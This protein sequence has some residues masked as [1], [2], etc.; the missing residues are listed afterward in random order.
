[1]CRDRWVDYQQQISGKLCPPIRKFVINE[2]V[3]FI[4]DIADGATLSEKPHQSRSDKNIPHM[5]SNQMQPV[6]C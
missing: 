1:M 3:L 4:H 6:F 5:Y 2:R